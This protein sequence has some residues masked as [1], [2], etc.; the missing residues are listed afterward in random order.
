MQDNK[1]YLEDLSKTKTEILKQIKNIDKI[2]ADEKIL[3]QEYTERNSKLPNKEKIFSV[4]HLKII[5]EKER[6]AKLDQ[7]KQC[8]KQMEPNEFVKLKKELEEKSKFFEDI[9]LEEKADERTQINKLQLQFLDCFMEKIKKTENKA[10]I[11]NLIYELRYYEQI[12]YMDSKIYE[13]QEVQEKLKKIETELINKSCK[14]KI[15]IRITNEEQLNTR[16]LS[17]QFKSKMINLENMVYILRY[18]KG[19]LRIEIFDTDVE[20]DVKEIELTDK[21]ELQVKLNKKI[22]LWE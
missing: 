17:N 10:N 2:L 1:K 20:D 7:I 13:F 3:K 18:H 8:N 15:L 14:E 4:S 16:I 22:K 19:V 21:V 9:R 5:L 12:P 6:E 11:R